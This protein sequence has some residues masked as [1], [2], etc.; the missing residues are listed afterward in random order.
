[1]C[2]QQ[3]SVTVFTPAVRSPTNPATEEGVAMKRRMN[4][5]RQAIELGF[6]LLF[7]LFKILENKHAFRL[8]RDGRKAYRLGVVCFFLMNTYTC[9]NGNVVS[10][11]FFDT[12]PPTL[13]EYIPLDEVLDEYNIDEPQLV[14]D[15]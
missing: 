3:Y 11:S 13:A 5:L 6:G 15:Y 9:L 1:M 2:C 12:Q 7:H 10:S 4:S 14:F 8:L